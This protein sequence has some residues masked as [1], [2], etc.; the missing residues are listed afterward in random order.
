MKPKIQLYKALES[1]RDILVETLGDSDLKSI[2]PR[3]EDDE[4][5]EQPKAKVM[6]FR[7]LESADRKSIED[8]ILRLSIDGSRVTREERMKVIDVI[9]KIDKQID[10]LIMKKKD[11]MQEYG[12]VGDDSSLVPDDDGF[13]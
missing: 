1:I 9:E 13:L 5:E 8:D 7:P 4:D 2:R 6:P 12:I 11:L 10:F 3:D